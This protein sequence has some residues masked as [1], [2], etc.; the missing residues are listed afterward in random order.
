MYTKIII[1]YLPGKELAISFAIHPYLYPRKLCL[2]GGGGY[3]VLT[4]S[5]RPSVCPQHI[6]S[7]NEIHETW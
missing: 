2:G 7:L 4:L 5:F 6:K 3:T 1:T